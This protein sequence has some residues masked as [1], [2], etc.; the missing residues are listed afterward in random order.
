MGWNEERF[1]ARFFS[2]FQQ[3]TGRHPK[4]VDVDTA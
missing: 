4:I 3:K 2:A 1:E